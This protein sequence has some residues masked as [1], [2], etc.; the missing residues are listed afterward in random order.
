[1]LRNQSRKQSTRLS[2]NQPESNRRRRD[3]RRRLALERLE[4]RTLLAGTWTP[5]GATNPSAGPT[6]TLALMLLS[7]GTVMVQAGTSPTFA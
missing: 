7:D 5:L 4:D 2:R 3:E 6:N 1:M